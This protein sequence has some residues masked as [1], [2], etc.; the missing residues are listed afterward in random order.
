MAL[1]C[2]WPH[3]APSSTL[4]CDGI[5]IKTYHCRRPA[6]AVEI[7][8]HLILLATHFEPIGCLAPVTSISP[9]LG[10][11]PPFRSASSSYISE[12]PRVCCPWS[13]LDFSLS[14]KCSEPLAKTTPS[15]ASIIGHTVTMDDHLSTLPFLR[16][17][18]WGDK[19][20]VRISEDLY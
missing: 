16:F 10:L 20:F 14:S 11:I 7:A 5:N 4:T 8:Q 9:L 1:P 12:T 6:S 18:V 13:L 3:D 17:E 2:H 19:I 15:F